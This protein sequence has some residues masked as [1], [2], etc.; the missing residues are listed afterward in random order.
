MEK[1]ILY[2]IWMQQVFDCGSPKPVQLWR[3]F[4]SVRSFFEQPRVFWKIPLFFPKLKAVGQ[5][6]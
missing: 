6:A 1:T 5:E 4:S 2:W 3:K